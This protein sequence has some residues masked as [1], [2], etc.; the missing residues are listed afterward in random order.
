MSTSTA[1]TDDTRLSFMTQAEQESNEEVKLEPYKKDDVSE[2][3]LK[4]LQ[5][6]KERSQ[7]V[8][9]KTFRHY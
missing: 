9:K 7:N 3:A 5:E 2:R 8:P 1:S 4:L 6:T